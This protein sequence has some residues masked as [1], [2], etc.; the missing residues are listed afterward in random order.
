[1]FQD[2][3]NAKGK[4]ETKFWRTKIQKI[5]QK[6]CSWNKAN[7]KSLTKWFK[8]QFHTKE[9][10][11][12]D[13]K[14][15]QNDKKKMRLYII[16]SNQGISLWKSET[17]RIMRKIKSFHRV[18]EKRFKNQ[19]CFGL[20][21]FYHSWNL[22]KSGSSECWIAFSAIFCKVE[23]PSNHFHILNSLINFLNISLSFNPEVGIIWPAGQIRPSAWFH[24]GLWVK[25]C[26]D[27]FKWLKILKE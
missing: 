4:T 26:F 10:N 9:L 8:K 15:P 6:L 12:L 11:F 5:R 17:L 13:L 24:N 25:C 1:M 14:G 20:L 21:I 23:E 7:K 2:I 3:E 18:K 22:K 27:R 16:Y 19:N